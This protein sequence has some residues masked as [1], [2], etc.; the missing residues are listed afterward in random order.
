MDPEVVA[1]GVS[2]SF[3]GPCQDFN[4]TLT[5]FYATRALS[6]QRQAILTG[7]HNAL[8]KASIPL[9]SPHFTSKSS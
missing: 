3:E 7:T 2:V 6:A 4:R 9:H 1:G 8:F 5:L